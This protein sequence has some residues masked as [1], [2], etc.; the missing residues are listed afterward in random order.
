M[1]LVKIANEL[2]PEV[3]CE[4][5]IDSL[6]AWIFANKS[7]DCRQR[8]GRFALVT[9]AFEDN[10][11]SLCHRSSEI[12]SH[13]STVKLLVHEFAMSNNRLHWFL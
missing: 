12:N 3:F 9:M 13:M 7:L 1:L 6:V 2:I 8:N 10:E 5:N 4:A 11:V